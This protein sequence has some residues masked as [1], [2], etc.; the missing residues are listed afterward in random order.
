ME[1]IGM[2]FSEFIAGAI[3]VFVIFSLKDDNNLGA[4]NLIRVTLVSL[5]LALGA[6]LE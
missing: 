3:S 5:I 6:R 1:R 4:G 2:F